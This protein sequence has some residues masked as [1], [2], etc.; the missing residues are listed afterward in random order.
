MLTTPRD[1]SAWWQCAFCGDAV[2]ISQVGTGLILTVE[3]DGHL[4]RQQLAA[5][6]ECLAGRLHPQTTF[7]PAAFE[8]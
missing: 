2:D 6:A 4:A 5:H 1:D 7:D 8:D 3:R